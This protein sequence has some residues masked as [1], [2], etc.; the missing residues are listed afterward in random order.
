MGIRAS[1]GRGVALL[2]AFLWAGG[3]AA[4]PS[5]VVS[6]TG[7]T[8]KALVETVRQVSELVKRADEPPPPPAVLRQRAQRDRTALSDAL[9]ALGYYDDRLRIDVDDAATPMIATITVE[10]GP[11]YTIGD[12]TVSET[13]GAPRV[14]LDRKVLGVPTGTPAAGSTIVDADRKVEAQYAAKGWLYAKVTDRRVVVD[15]ATRTAS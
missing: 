12:Y 13:I 5:Y 8:D 11:R 1:A 14:S 15:H 7:S 6:I 9:R 3:A 10:P 2:L 4:D